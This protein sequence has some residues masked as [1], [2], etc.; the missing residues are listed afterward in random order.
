MVREEFY[1]KSVTGCNSCFTYILSAFLCKDDINLLAL[2]LEK[3]L[4]LC[5]R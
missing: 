5:N 4:K 2:C 3:L 1:I